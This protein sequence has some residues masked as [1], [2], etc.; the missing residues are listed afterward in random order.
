M[1]SRAFQVS[2]FRIFSQIRPPIANRIKASGISVRTRVAKRGVN[3][4]KPNAHTATKA[5][6]QP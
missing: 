4:L 2:R 6:A 5:G 3:K 1:R